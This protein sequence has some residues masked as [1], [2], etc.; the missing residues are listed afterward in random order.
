MTDIPCKT[1]AINAAILF[2]ITRYGK[3]D[4]LSGDDTVM[5]ASKRMST[6]C[7]GGRSQG[8]RRVSC[9]REIPS[10]RISWAMSQHAALATATTHSLA[11]EGI[12][13]NRI[14]ECTVDVEKEFEKDETE[15]STSSTPPPL[16][17]PPNVTRSFGSIT[18]AERQAIAP[19]SNSIEAH[20][21]I[22]LPRSSSTNSSTP[23]SRRGSSL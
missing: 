18:P 23:T 21:H 11:F 8:A 1:V 13:I 20:H 9:E 10:R 14:Q 12:T 6:D 22:P 19:F 16:I 15:S 3:Q 4:E 17:S 7:S 5:Q 2:F